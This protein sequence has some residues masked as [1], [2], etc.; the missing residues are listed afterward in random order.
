MTILYNSL[1]QWASDDRRIGTFYYMRSYK[2]VVCWKCFYIFFV[3]VNVCVY[4]VNTSLVTQI[5]CEKLTIDSFGNWRSWTFARTS[6]SFFKLMSLKQYKILIFTIKARFSLCLQKL[7]V[8]W[9][10][11][12]RSWNIFVTQHVLYHLQIKSFLGYRKVIYRKKRIKTRR[13]YEMWYINKSPS[14][15]KKIFPFGELVLLTTKLKLPH[16]TFR[17]L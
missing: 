17:F 11:F 10:T 15:V 8:K 7:Q 16:F 12:Q 9:K 13:T 2:K 1:I 3:F 6:W 14:K 5:R 4:L